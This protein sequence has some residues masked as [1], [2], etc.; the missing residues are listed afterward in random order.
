MNP[1][2]LNPGPLLAGAAVALAVGFSAGWAINGWRLHADVADLKLENAQQITQASQVALEDYKTGAKAIKEAA[3]IGQADYS[4][5]LAKLD[6]I[7]RRIKNAKPPPLPADCKPG[8][9]RLRNLAEAAA[10]TD[11]AAARPVSGK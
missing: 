11:Q 3:S 6:T 10:A 9:D 2:T 4:A 8:P 1:L 5:A 7:D